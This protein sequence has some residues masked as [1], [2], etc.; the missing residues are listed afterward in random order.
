MKKSTIAGNPKL[1]EQPKKPTFYRFADA[2]GNG[3]FSAL[4]ASDK[5]YEVVVPATLKAIA[6]SRPPREESE[7]GVFDVDIP[8]YTDSNHPQW[9]LYYGGKK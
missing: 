4:R 6:N 9:N 3:L 7:R 1:T 5:A 8:E 2:L